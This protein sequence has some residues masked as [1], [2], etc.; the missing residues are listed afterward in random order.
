MNAAVYGAVRLFQDFVFRSTIGS[1]GPMQAAAICNRI[2]AE[3][4]DRRIVL[5]LPSVGLLGRLEE[6]RGSRARDA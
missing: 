1:I 3:L 4:F 2:E 6:D 5:S